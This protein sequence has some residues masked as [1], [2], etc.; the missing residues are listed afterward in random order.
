MRKKNRKT[1]SVTKKNNN[2]ELEITKTQ[3][4]HAITYY[5]YPLTLN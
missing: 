5:M 4:S 1:M 2:L 3:I